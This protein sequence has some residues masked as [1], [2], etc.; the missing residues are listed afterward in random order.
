MESDRSAVD[1]VC[2]AM[3]FHLWAAQ[4]SPSMGADLDRASGSG[5]P[6]GWNS[7]GLVAGAEGAGAGAPSGTAW[8]PRS[9]PETGM[10]PAL[11]MGQA[12]SEHEGPSLD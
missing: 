2:W 11:T 12:P 1:S 5:F 8:A 7:A 3:S 4:R 10:C 9:H 6:G